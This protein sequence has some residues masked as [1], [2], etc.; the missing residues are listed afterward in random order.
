MMRKKRPT[1]FAPA[2]RASAQEIERQAHLFKSERLL[3]FLPDAVPCILLV[4]N[5]QRQLV[6]VND[7][8]FDLL[9]AEQRGINVLGRRP[10]EALGCVHA[11]EAEGGCGTTDFCSTCGAVHAILA[12]QNG[13]ADVQECRI[14]RANGE[15]LDFRVWTTP[16]TMDG[17]AFT[18][19][20]ALDIR[21]E[22]RREALEHIF[23][24][25]INNVAYGLSWYADFFRNAGPEKIKEYADAIRRLSREL[26]EEIEA[27]RILIKAESGELTLSPEP[28]SSRQLL[29]DAVALY[30]GHPASHDRRLRVDGQ[31][32]DAQ[33]VSDRVLLSRV[34]CNMVRNALEACRAGET[35]TVGCTTTGGTIELWVH[36]PGCMPREVQLQVFQR[37]FS[38]KGRGRG[39]GTY[40]IKLLTERYLKGIASFTSTPEQGTTFRVRCPAALEA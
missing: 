26:I 38:T 21:D 17:E 37:S 7:R 6:F 30:S 12:S 2:D 27:Q 13:T 11:E 25:D 23:L 31:C 29:Q 9:P 40:S 28:V 35:T 20:A 22:K 4:V 18:I 15:A 5:T 34:L 14:T 1:N 19:F 24:H 8:F 33:M 3:G 10:G 39:L 16:V 32:P 36:N